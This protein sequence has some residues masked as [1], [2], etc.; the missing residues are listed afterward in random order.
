MEISCPSFLSCSGSSDGDGGYSS[1]ETSYNEERMSFCFLNSEGLLLPLVMSTGNTISLSQDPASIRDPALSDLVLATLGKPVLDLAIFSSTL[2]IALT[3]EGLYGVSTRT[4]SKEDTGVLLLGGTF[5]GLA[6]QAPDGDCPLILT[7]SASSESTS[8]L[9][10]DI[11]GDVYCQ[12]IPLSSIPSDVLPFSQVTSISIDDNTNDVFISDGGLQKVIRVNLLNYSCVQFC[13]FP[14]DHHV[15]AC[16][17]LPGRLLVA[18]QLND[19][20]FLHVY[21]AVAE[22]SEYKKPLTGQKLVKL[23]F[24]K[25]APAMLMDR[26]VEILATI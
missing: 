4:V 3:E 16:L 21:D 5:F 25:R 2:L 26:K 6:V 14:Q 9:V 12:K 1:H 24:L 13:M 22:V 7:T 17:A 11:S 20:T 19:Q 8:L 23:G 15:L 10:I 18:V